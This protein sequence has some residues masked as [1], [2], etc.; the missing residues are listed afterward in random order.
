MGHQLAQS[1]QIGQK[2]RCHIS[3]EKKEQLLVSANKDNSFQK[4]GRV[5][6]IVWQVSHLEIRVRFLKARLDNL[7]ALM[8]EI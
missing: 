7:T 6:C 2:E 1:W 8:S 3:V 5:Q 4:L